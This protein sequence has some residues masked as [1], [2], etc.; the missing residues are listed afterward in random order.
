MVA[1]RPFRCESCFHRFFR[2]PNALDKRRRPPAI[3]FLCRANVTRPTWRKPNFKS[4]REGRVQM[5]RTA[6]LIRCGA[7]E[8][9]MIR[10]QAQKKHHTISSYVL[11]V[12]LKVVAQGPSPS[13]FNHYRRP[14]TAGERSA[15]LVRCTVSEAEQIRESARRCA[16]PINVFVL[17]AL[18]STWTH[19]TLPASETETPR[20]LNTQSSRMN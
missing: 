8:A 16:V 14:P 17:R 1:L 18:K 9:D 15:V 12:A 6:L 3:L 5:T 10:V 20:K 19:S 7:D 13:E 11:S 4:E 2:W